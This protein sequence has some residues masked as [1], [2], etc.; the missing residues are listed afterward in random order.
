MVQ[1]NIKVNININEVFEPVE[2]G[3]LNALAYSAI[4]LNK[5]NKIEVSNLY[6][7]E[8][9]RM[10][11]I[12][13]NQEKFITSFKDFVV[14][15]ALC[16]MIANLET[17]IDRAYKSFLP[18]VKSAKNKTY[19]KKEYKKD[20][21][22]FDKF[23]FEEK[24][25]EIKKFI[26]KTKDNEQL[27]LNLKYVRNCIIHNGCIVKNGEVKL[28][29]PYISIKYVDMVTKE[30][31][32]ANQEDHSITMGNEKGHDGELI[33]EFLNKEKIFKHGETIKFTD[34]EV[35]FLIY[36]MDKSIKLL[37]KEF[38]YLLL[39]NGMPINCTNGIVIMTR[40]ELDKICNAN[41]KPMR[42]ELYPINKEVLNG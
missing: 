23:T 18:I 29:I 41:S 1:K 32:Y 33:I 12:E 3:I 8:Q 15:N 42:I 4:V 11:N 36:A 10:V 19:L 27:W 34:K 9:Y 17:T 5:E 37:Y 38:M 26:K 20:I 40:D 22:K 2:N 6:I 39:D 16:C 28:E 13:D 21:R 35:N 24:L 7:H 31:F 25:K 30:E 14:Y